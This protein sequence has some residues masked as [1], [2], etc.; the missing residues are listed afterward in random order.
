MYEVVGLLV[1]VKEFS[2]VGKMPGVVQE[3]CL[4]TFSSY[5]NGK[6]TFF[7]ERENRENVSCS[8]GAYIV[9][10]MLLTHVY[11]KQLLK[12]FHTTT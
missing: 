1:D 2:L 8:H 12:K 11:T 4:L 3:H 9:M 10:H 7:S 6:S 5:S